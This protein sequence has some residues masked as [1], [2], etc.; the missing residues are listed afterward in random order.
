MRK[1]LV[2]SHPQSLMT[3]MLRYLRNWPKVQ[4]DH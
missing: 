3:Y 2:Y 1:E 4:S